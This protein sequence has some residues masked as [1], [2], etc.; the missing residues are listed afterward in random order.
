MHHIKVFMY[1]LVLIYKQSCEVGNIIL[2]LKIKWVLLRQI[3]N[4]DDKASEPE[5]RFSLISEII[6]GIKPNSLNCK[7]SWILKQSSS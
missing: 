1:V 7:L 4:Q 5:L 6:L 2:I 3:F